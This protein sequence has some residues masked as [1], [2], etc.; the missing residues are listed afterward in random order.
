MIQTAHLRILKLK[1][2]Q[3]DWKFFNSTINFTFPDE[4]YHEFLIK[5][6][7]VKLLITSFL[8]V[9]EIF[10]TTGICS[11]YFCST[12]LHHFRFLGMSMIMVYEFGWAWDITSLNKDCSMHCQA[13]LA[14]YLKKIKQLLSLSTFLWRT[15]WN[16]EKLR[17]SEYIT[18]TQFENH[19][20]YSG[21]KVNW[22][23]S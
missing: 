23:M 1:R 16:S 12:V 18:E 19:S 13:F 9:G 11:Q 3:K 20:F 4:K 8:T 7:G 17:Y 15:L 22:I 10:Q 6:I 14:G 21:Q 5:I 2:L